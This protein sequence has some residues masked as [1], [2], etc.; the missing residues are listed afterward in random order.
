MVCPDWCDALRT[1][2]DCCSIEK[3]TE[4][5]ARCS[6]RD[7]S[8][9][10]T[11]CWPPAAAVVAMC[12]EFHLI[13]VTTKTKSKSDSCSIVAAIDTTVRRETRSHLLP[14]QLSFYFKMNIY[15]HTHTLSL[16][17]WYLNFFILFFCCFVCCFLK[18]RKIISIKCFALC[19]SRRNRNRSMFS[20][21]LKQIEWIIIK[22]SKN[23]QKTRKIVVE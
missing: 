1:A 8:V 21:L 6:Q 18:E 3:E 20:C 16:L 14:L 4:R 2:L 11:S 10:W 5:T 15:K 7:C 23:T 9:N 22:S 19:L 17:V 13:E 12:C